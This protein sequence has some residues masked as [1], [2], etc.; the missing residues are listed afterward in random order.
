MVEIRLAINSNLSTF[1]F[2]KIQQIDIVNK[3]YFTTRIWI[4]DSKTIKKSDNMLDKITFLNVR[5]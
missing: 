3:K 5:I 1:P 4:V 2:L